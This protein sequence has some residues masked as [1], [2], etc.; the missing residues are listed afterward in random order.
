MAF[1]SLSFKFCKVFMFASFIWFRLQNYTKKLINTTPIN[2]EKVI[3]TR[4]KKQEM[5]MPGN[6]ENIGIF[7]DFY[8]KKQGFWQKRKAKSTKMK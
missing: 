6:I 1:A 3:K 5:E 2:I 4:S 7:R 8:T